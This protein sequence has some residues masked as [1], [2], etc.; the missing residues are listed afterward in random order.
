M[1]FSDKSR[2]DIERLKQQWLDDPCW[3]IENTEG[4]DAHREELLE[5]R[6]SVEKKRDMAEMQLRFRKAI[7]RAEKVKK[8]NS[9][10]GLDNLALSVMLADMQERLDNQAQLLQYV[11]GALLEITASF[12]DEAKR[13]DAWQAC[14]QAIAIH[15]GGKLF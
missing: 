6:D 13:N 10:L 3:D 5:F 14:V 1:A 4:F 7:E 15:K 12:P 2:E 11:M 9:E 8:I